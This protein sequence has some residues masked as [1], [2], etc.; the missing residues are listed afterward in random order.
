MYEPFYVSLLLVKDGSS[1][2][3]YYFK[4]FV[5]GCGQIQFFEL[6]NSDLFKKHNAAFIGHIS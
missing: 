5:R 1:S 2:L 4:G 3:D 6:F